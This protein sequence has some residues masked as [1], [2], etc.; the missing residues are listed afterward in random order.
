MLSHVDDI[1]PDNL[2]EPQFYSPVGKFRSSNWDLIRED[3]LRIKRENSEK[4]LSQG[5]DNMSKDLK[6]GSIPSGGPADIVDGADFDADTVPE[7][8]GEKEN[9]STKLDKNHTQAL[10][11]TS[12][13]LASLNLAQGQN[14]VMFTFSTSMLGAQKVDTR[15]YL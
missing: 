6:D 2:E 14:T 5:G 3:A 10:T 1:A 13:H 8:E 4:Q 9:C 7:I 15:I 12:E 11:P